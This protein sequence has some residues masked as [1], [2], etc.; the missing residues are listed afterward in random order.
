MKRS[1]L[2]LFGLALISS[3][4]AQNLY[5]I[6][7][8]SVDSIPLTWRV[9][10]DLIWDSNV[11]PSIPSGSIGHEE[12]QWSI[13]PYIE[14]NQTNVSDQ[15]TLN[16]YARVGA[17]YYFEDMDATG[18][19]QF[20]PSAKLGVDYSHSFSERLRFSS[21]NYLS[22]EMEPNYSYGISRERSTDPYFFYSSDNSIGYRWTQRVGSYT[23]FAFTGYIDD[24]GDSNFAD[25][26]SWA[27]YHQMRYQ[28]NQRTVL[29]GAYRYE[30]WTGDASDSTNHYITGGF[31]HRM[32]QNSVF[33]FNAGIQLRDVDGGETSNSP[34]LEAVMRSQINSAFSIRGFVRYSM[35]DY[36]TIQ[37]V[38]L[39]SYE[40]NEQQVLRVGLSGEYNLTPRLTGYGGVDVVFT[41]YDGG[42]KIAGPGAATDSGRSQ[43]LYNIYIGLRAKL[44]DQLTGHCSINY[45]DSISDF[46]TREYDRLRLSCGVSYTF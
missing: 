34:F 6:G 41:S 15:T 7:Q 8:E 12:E 37:F 28:L 43:D 3:A 18:G 45:S 46:A 1:T 10:T 32:S 38:G 21:R 30:Q 16:F 13:N 11:N 36:D 9:G 42:N 44:T 27:F 23:G 40:Y 29:T 35:E 33:V 19:E 20:T 2:S 17:N 4:S 22:Y 25:R 31:E 5:Y 26:S 39:N 24:S 14:V